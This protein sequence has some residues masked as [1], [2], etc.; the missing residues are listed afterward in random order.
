MHFQET[1]IWYNSEVVGKILSWIFVEFPPR[2]FENFEVFFKY[3]FFHFFSSKMSLLF[4]KAQ[5]KLIN[6]ILQQKT[7]SK[8]IQDPASHSA[9]IS[10][11][12]LLLFLFVVVIFFSAFE[13]TLIKFWQKK[14]EK[15]SCDAIILL[16]KEIGD[17]RG[18]GDHKN[19]L[20]RLTPCEN[21]H[22]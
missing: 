5:K 8:E 15:K 18:Q 9:K 20:E 21:F 3:K 12:N 10:K 11:K 14:W 7:Q 22:H 1:F 19:R 2:R 13:W 4:Q 16:R 17:W 6:Q